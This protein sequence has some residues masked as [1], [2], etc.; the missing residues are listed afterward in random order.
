[1]IH[2][3]VSAAALLFGL[4]TA[5]AAQAPDSLA[6]PSRPRRVASAPT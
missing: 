5:A 2:P 6:A 1:M 4:A 3:L